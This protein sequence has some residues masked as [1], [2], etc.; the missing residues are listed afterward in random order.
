[1]TR[2]LIL[3]LAPTISLWMLISGCHD[4]DD[5][6]VRYHRSGPQRVER[7]E[8]HRETTVYQVDRGQPRRVE[9]SRRPPERHE[10][11]VDR[12]HGRDK[13]RDGDDRDDDRSDHKS[14]QDP[15][16]SRSSRDSDRPHRQ[17]RDDD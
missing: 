1:M 2:R 15:D 9:S 11:D 13:E 5:D 3:L 8:V 16:R 7:R 14:S 17:E 6:Q 12:D 4:H 10:R